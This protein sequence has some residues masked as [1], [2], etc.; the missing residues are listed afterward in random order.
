MRINAQGME[1][2]VLN[3]KIKETPDSEV[4]LEHVGGQRYIG[5]GTSGKTIVID[6]VPGNALGAYLNGSTII[7]NSNTQDATGD[8]MN[9]GEIIIHGN[10]GDACGYAMRGG[11]IF[12]RGNAGYRAGIHMKAYGTQ[13]PALVI[14]GCAGNFLGEYQ[15][16][17][18][19]VVL[20]LE[21]SQVPV[22][23]FCGTGIHGGKIFLRCAS[24]PSG[25]PSQVLLHKA[26]A[27]DLEEIMP[28]LQ[29]FSTLFSVDMREILNKNF[30][31]LTPN[32]NN[33]YK[34]LYTQN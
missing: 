11:K 28:E 14:G 29:R 33:P 5:T 22:G 30:Y 34:Q 20:G 15:A 12:V 7:C 13:R 19:I 25:F 32:T 27:Q 16:G 17:G 10:S 2:S 8:T 1:Y 26:S 6:G 3:R 21:N 31:I 24:E 18:T 9:Q 23:D 4:V